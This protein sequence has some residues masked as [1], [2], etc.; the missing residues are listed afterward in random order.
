MSY[1][2]HP[3]E[4]RAFTVDFSSRLH[5]VPFSPTGEPD[6]TYTAEVLTGTPTVVEQQ[7][8]AL[9]IANVA[10]NTVALWING[11]N[12]PANQG[13]TFTVA[14][15]TTRTAYTVRVTV[16]TDGDPAQTLI[17]DIRVQVQ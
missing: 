9:T 2:K 6:G 10:L 4:T 11:R 14:G 13:V 3:G 5:T 16:A 1:T 17:K 7:T 15:G 8:S 12:I